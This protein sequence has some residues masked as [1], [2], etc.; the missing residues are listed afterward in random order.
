M[1]DMNDEDT[2]IDYITGAEVPDM[3]AEANRQAFERILVEVKGFSKSEVEVDVP[4][5]LIVSGKP[6][7]SRIDLVV[8][9]EGRRIMAVKCAAGSL[10]SRE[11]EILAAARLLEAYQIP[12][13]IV[14]DGKS[15]VM[16]DTVSGEVKGEG[17]EPI[18]TRDALADMLKK[19]EWVPFPEKRQEREKLIF[20][21]YDLENVNVRRNIPDNNSV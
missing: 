6:Y 16:L 7:S 8:G 13:S 3:G 4:L 19:M 11:R 15:A 10:G 20:R 5:A 14:T 21:S 9:L 18:P 1:S 17:I 12:I 2:I